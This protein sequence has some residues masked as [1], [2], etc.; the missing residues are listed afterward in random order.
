MA[1]ILSSFHYQDLKKMYLIAH[2]LKIHKL[3]RCIAA[4]FAAKV[5]AKDIDEYTQKKEL[6]GIDKDISIHTSIEYKT[7]PF[8]NNYV[9]H[10]H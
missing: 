8:M 3:K 10:Q 6:Y 9:S 4:H 5:Y 1:E 7:L 2:C